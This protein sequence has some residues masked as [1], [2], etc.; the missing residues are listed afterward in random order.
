MPIP[1]GLSK[2]PFEVNQPKDRWKPDLDPVKDNFQQYYAPFV[3]NIRKHLYEWRQ[4]GYPD[5]SDTS[6]ELYFCDDLG[7]YGI[8]WEHK[9]AEKVA[10]RFK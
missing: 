7:M 10:S 5:I 1:I 4:F 9:N 3:Q 6:R 8:T 2:S